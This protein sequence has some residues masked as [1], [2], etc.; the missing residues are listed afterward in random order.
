MEM[1]A[2]GD[3]FGG[4]TLVRPL[5]THD[6]V[7]VWEATRDA[8][9]VAVAL[10]IASVGSSGARRLRREEASLAHVTSRMVVA[11]ADCVEADGR[12]MLALDWC[13]GGTLK[14]RLAAEGPLSF[15]AVR[16]IACDLLAALRD[17]HAAGVVHRDLKPGNVFLTESGEAR[18]GDFGIAL[19]PGERPKRGAVV[20]SA[21]YMSPEQAV[22]G[23]LDARSDLYSLGLVLHELV[24]GRQVFSGPDFA[25][26]LR[27]AATETAPFLASVAPDVP[28]AFARFVAALTER[29]RFLRP[30][31]A[32]ESLLYLK[33]II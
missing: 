4:F 10:K 3:S 28:V 6:E 32:V 27:R 7:E 15:Y 12:M 17:V 14:S 11:S 25:A 24:T 26:K 9:G 16:D 22:G 23:R 19:L 20:G 8:D 13:R 21:A 2:A 31:S 5:K 1:S 18:L 33:A 29:D 30:P